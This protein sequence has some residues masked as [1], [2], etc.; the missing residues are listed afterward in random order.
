MIKHK[1]NNEN[2]LLNFRK[3]DQGVIQD[4]FFDL[5]SKDKIMLLEC[6][7]RFT[8]E[9]QHFELKSITALR[10]QNNGYGSFIMKKVIELAKELEVEYIKGSISPNDIHTDELKSKVYGFYK[11]HL[12][13]IKDSSFIIDLKKHN[14][15]LELLE[16][17]SLKKDLV[18][19]EEEKEYL[20][21]K[22]ERLEEIINSLK[23]GKDKKIDPLFKN[24]VGR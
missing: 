10:D 13:E 9:L 3:V 1:L 23:Q 12:A 18:K 17:Q 4:Y 21:K 20:L 7:V 6:W 8:P 2:V 16:I 24:I 22:N 15:I 11:K 14:N 19:L 5:Y